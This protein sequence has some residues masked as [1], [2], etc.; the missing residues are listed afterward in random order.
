[1]KRT[2]MS[3]TLA[4]LIAPMAYA[5]TTTTPATNGNGLTPAQKT[6]VQKVVHTYLVQNP[7][8]VIEALQGYQQK[9]M[10][11]AQKMMQKTQESA[12]TFAND[13]FKNAADPVIGNPNG[14]VTL[15]EFFDYQCGHCVAMTSTI[16]TVVKTNPQLRV[17]FKEFPIR[18]PISEFAAKAAL[19]AKNQGKYLQLHDALMQANGRLSNDTILQIAAAQGLNVNTLKT[20]MDSVSIN[21][22]IKANYK[23][24]QDLG[25]MGT[26]ALFIAKTNVVSNPTANAITFV[27]GR[28]EKDQLQAMLDKANK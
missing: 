1:M 15:V 10:Q 26:P 3:V 22:Q 8:V 2:L 4:A 23:L 16:N 7:E 18:G 6:D 27:P 12:V 14:T 28:V 19:A 21:N 5:A 9:Q 25:L 11:Q 20:D 13:I 24:A 17:V